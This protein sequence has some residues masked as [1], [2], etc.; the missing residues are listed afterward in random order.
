MGVP[1]LL[2]HACGRVSAH[3]MGIAHGRMQKGRGNF[4]ALP[5]DCVQC[6]K[7]V[8]PNP[9]GVS[10]YSRERGLGTACLCHMPS[11]LPLMFGD[12]RYTQSLIA[13]GHHRCPDLHICSPLILFFII[14]PLVYYA[15]SFSLSNTHLNMTST[16]SSF[17]PPGTFSSV[18]SPKLHFPNKVKLQLQWLCAQLFH[19]QYGSPASSHVVQEYCLQG[20]HVLGMVLTNDVVLRMM[21]MPYI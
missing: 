18:Y 17:P 13:T 7:R 4:A 6:S 15:S 2:W 11:L 8:Q 3:V 5:F 14:S 16:P 12:Y 10:M 21:R 20:T 9:V 19:T 1:A